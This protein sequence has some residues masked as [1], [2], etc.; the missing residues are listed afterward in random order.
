V[1][2]GVTGESGTYV[3]NWT[4]E[5][6][7]AQVPVLTLQPRSQTVPAGGVAAF[8]TRVTNIDAAAVFQWYRNGQPIAAA[9]SSNLVLQDVQSSELGQ[10]R[11]AVTNAS[12]RGAVS[13]PVD[14]EIGPDPGVQSQ[15][16]LAEIP[17]SGGGGGG[18]EGEL[19]FMMSAV[20]G[21]TF[22]LAAGTII[23]Q[24][25]FSSGTMDRCEPAHCGVPGGASRW[26]Q[27]AATTDGVCTVDTQGSGADTILAVYLLSFAV[28]TNL[29][30]PLVDCNNDVL[31]S[32][33]QLVV[34]NGARERISRVSFMAAAGTSYRAVVDTA[35]GIR[36]TNIQFNVHFAAQE[37]LPANRVVLDTTQVCLLERRGASLTLSVATNLVTP[38]NLYQWQ[39]NHRRIA[40]A[41]RPELVL[42]FLN[43]SD[44]GRYS[45]L[46]QNGVS[47]TV[48][49]GAAVVVVD[50]CHPAGGGVVPGRFQ[51]VGATAEPLLLEATT[52]L[53]STSSW[54]VIAPIVPSIEPT[55]WDST[56]ATSRFYRASRP[57]P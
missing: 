24:R 19:P 30:E 51:L 4:L 25:F 50:P 8:F 5:A 37:S 22:S 27:L 6:T 21:G 28:C 39:V 1:I 12:G 20:S 32:C 46:V 47:Q 18:G 10:Y 29:Y 23:N 36:G 15:D 16:K 31:G 13:I 53:L 43:Y 42:P 33:D 11:L 57:P 45:V 55:L 49:P 44:A 7:A 3:C 26:F 9:T 41:A 56:T 52:S 40:G 14:L 54:E 35:G 17:G 48:L 2:D 38:G 34:T